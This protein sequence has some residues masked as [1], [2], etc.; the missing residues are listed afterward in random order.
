MPATATKW[1][2]PLIKDLKVKTDT[3]IPLPAL[4]S[5]LIENV[6]LSR[7]RGTI[8]RND[9]PLIRNQILGRQIKREMP[10]IKT[11]ADLRKLWAANQEVKTVNIPI[12]NLE[13]HLD[14]P[15]WSAGLP[16]MHISSFNLTPREV[17]AQ[18][19][20][21]KDHFDKIMKS[22]LK[23]PL[24]IINWNGRPTILDGL[25]RFAYAW[26]LGNS[27]VSTRELPNKYL[28]MLRKT[29]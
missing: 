14:M 13:W 2:R 22:Q 25:H 16:R 4:I 8:E 29:E 17:L 21:Y 12:E 26:L 20:K 15:L 5:V 7:L 28:P 6:N 24:S 27:F 19:D 9:L 18:P 23:Y 10:R 11:M 1:E 3:S